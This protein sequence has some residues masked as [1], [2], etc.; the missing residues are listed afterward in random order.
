MAEQTYNKVT[1]PEL[2]TDVVDLD[3][4]QPVVL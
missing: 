4:L 2:R 1:L 3:L